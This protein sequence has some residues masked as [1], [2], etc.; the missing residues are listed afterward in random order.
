MVYKIGSTAKITFPG[1]AISAIATSKANI[2]DMKKQMN[3]QFISHDKINQLRHVRFF[4]NLMESSSD[5]NMP[6]SSAEI[7]GG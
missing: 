6:R 2:E 7:R 4:K 3:V 5:A 1:S